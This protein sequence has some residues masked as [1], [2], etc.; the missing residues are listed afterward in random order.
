MLELLGILVGA[1]KFPCPSWQELGKREPRPPAIKNRQIS[2]LRPG[3]R[4][5]VA[6][7]G[8]CGADRSG[9]TLS[10]LSLSLSGT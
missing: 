2:A 8:R 7:E 9:A 5:I 4:N 10:A 3:I 1:S 6:A